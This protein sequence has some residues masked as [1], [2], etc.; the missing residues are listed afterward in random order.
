M[1]N[2]FWRVFPEKM[3][4]IP[5]L[6]IVLVVIIY[7]IA[8]T[9]VPT[10]SADRVLEKTLTDNSKKHGTSFS[11]VFITAE[12]VFH[13][14]ELGVM[15]VKGNV[16]ISVDDKVLL[17][18]LVSYDTKHDLIIATGN[19][20][21]LESGSTV[22]FSNYLELTDHLKRG[23]AQKIQALLAD[24]SRLTAVSGS[25]TKNRQILDNVVYTACNPSEISCAG[26]SIASFCHPLW[27]IKASKVIHDI[28]QQQ[29]AYYDAW[30]EMW[31]FPLIY[32]PY[33]SYPDPQVKRRSGYLAP[34]WGGTYNLGVTVR[35][36]YFWA[37]SPSSDITFEPLLSSKEGLA[38]I[39]GE[40]RQKLVSGNIKGKISIAHNQQ[41][42]IRGYIKGHAFYNV[43]P[44]KKI[45]VKMERTT[46][47][48]YMH[49]YGFSNTQPFLVTHGMLES[50]STKSYGS[51]S[52]YSFQGLRVIS[53]P[54]RT[55]VI[56]PL[57]EYS[58]IGD[59]IL[60]NTYPTLSTNFSTVLREGELSSQRLSVTSGL[61]IPYTNPGG[62][63]LTSN[64]H[65]R[66]DSYFSEKLRTTKRLSSDGSVVRAIPEVSLEWRY[67]IVKIAKDG[68]GIHTVLEP[69]ALF[70]ARTVL[71]RRV[72]DLPNIDS[73]TFEHSDFNV[74]QPNHLSGFDRVGTEPRLNYGFKI[75]QYYSE[76]IKLDAIVGQSYHLRPQKEFG[77][78]SGLA[79]TL[80]DIVSSIAIMPSDYLSLSGRFRLDKK[81][82]ATHHNEFSFAVGSNSLHANL[83]YV[84][85]SQLS[86]E[87]IEFADRRELRLG[88]ASSITKDWDIYFSTHYNLGKDGGLI[89]NVLG[90]SYED[91]CFIL[92]GNVSRDYTRDRDIEKG[93]SLM[94]QVAL[95][96]LDNSITKKSVRFPTSFSPAVRN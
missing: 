38:A 85:I 2:T 39:S 5:V 1:C 71:G 53:D 4:Q 55:P 81:N 90:T 95:K 96:S 59:P 74:F 28:E 89:A 76:T 19:V 52:I 75:S 70:S 37:I 6:Q 64:I 45:S 66:G 60:S 12:E 40:Y 72:V 15:T 17:A 62:H 25:Y 30:L 78:I 20:S 3:T 33:L 58:Y 16:E 84:F 50:F 26:V 31:G 80:S 77:T 18:D 24:R 47:S 9:S 91:E 44:S 51:A 54:E 69:V 88:L 27:Q 46:D 73:N 61:T 56:L 43:S 41:S 93:V 92:R 22:L 49:H 23:V 29:M 34:T 10:Y 21:L 8:F 36:P 86:R 87:E 94:I 68:D 35:V 57:I 82:L 42:N 7:S 83:D 63:I 13:N 11:S 65:L 79:G 48:T 32:T 67:P 14:R